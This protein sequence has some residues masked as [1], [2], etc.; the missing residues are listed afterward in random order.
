MGL[1]LHLRG[2]LN[3]LRL[4]LLRGLHLHLRGMLN[5]LR[6]LRLLSNIFD[7]I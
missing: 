5:L 3:L 2:M 6:G 1:H 7:I 4:N